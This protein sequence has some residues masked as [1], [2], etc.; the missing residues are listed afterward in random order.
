M[1]TVASCAFIGLIH[2]RKTFPWRSLSQKR[3]SKNN[4]CPMASS[5]PRMSKSPGRAEMRGSSWEREGQTHQDRPLSPKKPYLSTNVNP[6]QHESRVAMAAV[7]GAPHCSNVSGN[8]SLSGREWQMCDSIG[9][10]RTTSTLCVST[11]GCRGRSWTSHFG[12]F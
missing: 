9:N 2:R 3:R 12:S 7:E 10:G 5:K 11:L 4:L 8:L 1:S 6:W